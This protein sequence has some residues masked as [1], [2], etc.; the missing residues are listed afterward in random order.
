MEQNA[1]HIFPS[2]CHLPV[3][4]RILMWIFNPLPRDAVCQGL[5]T[6]RWPYIHLSTDI[7]ERS[8]CKLGGGWLLVST[9][10]PQPLLNLCTGI[11][12]HRTH[13]LSY[14]SRKKGNLTESIPI[15]NKN[16][17]ILKYTAYRFSDVTRY[18]VMRFLSSELTGKWIYKRGQDAK[19]S[20]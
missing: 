7:G 20:A 16:C 10:S 12:T 1:N 11:W 2:C 17:M 6:D 18:S 5:S 4:F 14:L 9:S 3:R 8:A 15:K 13:V 19:F